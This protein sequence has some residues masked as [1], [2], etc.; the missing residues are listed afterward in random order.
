MEEV[1]VQ[2]IFQFF[3]DRSCGRRA[4]VHAT[5]NHSVNRAFAQFSADNVA[6]MLYNTRLVPVMVNV[7]HVIDDVTAFADDLI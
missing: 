1:R 5:L 3:A 2:R 6:D 7:S 4:N